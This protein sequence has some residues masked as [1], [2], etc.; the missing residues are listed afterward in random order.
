M[1]ADGDAANGDDARRGV[2]RGEGLRG[3]PW[4]PLA[5]FCR[6]KASC[7]AAEGEMGALV[8]TGR[9]LANLTAAGAKPPPHLGVAPPGEAT[10]CERP[11]RARSVFGLTTF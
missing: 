5:E 10:I 3:V 11:R 6:C 9:P 1:A 7:L 8:E 4:P 2:L